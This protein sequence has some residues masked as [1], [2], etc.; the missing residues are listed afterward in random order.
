MA[1]KMRCSTSPGTSAAHAPAAGRRFAAT[2]P[3]ADSRRRP[4]PKPKNNRECALHVCYY[5]LRR[6][7]ADTDFLRGKRVLELGAGTSAVG[8]AAAVLGAAHVTVT[9]LP[10][11][12][13][14]MDRSIAL[15]GLQATMTAAPLDWSSVPGAYAPGIAAGA[16]DV[17]L[18]ADCIY[19]PRLVPWLVQTMDALI[20]PGTQMLLGYER[21]EGADDVTAMLL[22][23]DGCRDA[24]LAL[25]MI[26]P[27]EM[28]ADWSANPDVWIYSITRPAAG[29]AAAAAA[30][31]GPAAG[32]A[33]MGAATTS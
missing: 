31:A 5:L 4:V 22:L 25:D 27:D 23:L 3:A 6:A 32:A 16:F 28:H 13:P 9:D 21:R 8:L 26:P 1:C 17:I 18:A 12:V 7:G 33:A 29:T 10:A 11:L 19:A 24:G 15:N 2:H 30:A 20:A 14:R